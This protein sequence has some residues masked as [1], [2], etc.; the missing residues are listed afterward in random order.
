MRCT[1][2]P[3]RPHKRRRRPLPAKHL[4]KRPLPYQQ[5]LALKLRTLMKIKMTD[6]LIAGNLTSFGASAIPC[7]HDGVGLGKDRILF[8]AGRNRKH[9][10]SRLGIERA[11]DR[12]C[13]KPSFVGDLPGDLLWPANGF[14]D[15]LALNCLGRRGKQF[16]IAPDML[17]PLLLR[18]IAAVQVLGQLPKLGLCV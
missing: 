1:P 6:D 4:G 7:R 5:R 9:L 12:L 18:Q 3:T 17:V 11:A 8:G 10:S 2:N 14:R 16:G 15:S 13:A